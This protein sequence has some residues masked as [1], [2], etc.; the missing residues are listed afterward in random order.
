MDWLGIKFLKKLKSER[1]IE[2]YET[3]L[4]NDMTSTKTTIFK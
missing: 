1:K 3:I 4:A 2:E